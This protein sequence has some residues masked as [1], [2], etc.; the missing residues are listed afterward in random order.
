MSRTREPGVRLIEFAEATPADRRLQPG[1]HCH[2]ARIDVDAR[3]INVS[4][5]IDVGPDELHQEHSRVEDE[6]IEALGREADTARYLNF[7]ANT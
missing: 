7:R 2:D 3:R 5:H 4:H 6:V 1:L